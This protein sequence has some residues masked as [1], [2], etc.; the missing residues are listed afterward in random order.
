MFGSGDMKFSAKAWFLPLY[1]TA[2]SITAAEM[3][4][5]K[6]RGKNRV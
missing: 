4:V 6:K 1:Y 3:P 5:Y 2:N